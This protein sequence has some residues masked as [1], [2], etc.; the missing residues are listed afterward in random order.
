MKFN[1]PCAIVRDLLPSYAEGLTEEETTAAV[2]EHLNACTDCSRRYA[3]MTEGT[4]S[5]ATTSDKEVDY[6]KA[7]RKN[8]KKKMVLAVILAVVLV[9]GAVG[10]K[11]FLIGSPATGESVVFEVEQKEDALHLQFTCIDSASVLSRLEMQTEGDVVLITGRKTLVSPIHPTGGH[12]LSVSTEGIR[13]IRA[14]GRT[15]WQENLLVDFATNRLLDDAA[16]YVGDAPAVGQLISDLDLDVPST[17]ELQTAAAPYGVT[18]HFTQPIETN[19][20]FMVEGAAHLLLAL[21]GNLE[22]VSWDDP[23]GWTGSLTLEEANTAL[24][25]RVQRYN[26]LHGTDWT[27][28]DSVKHYGTDAYA[29]QQLRNLLGI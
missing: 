20:R 21:V 22:V 3:A 25:G 29:L 10:S 7:V 1:L 19:R 16:A 12:V 28:L 15:I 4:A 26:E 17:M 8:T 14:F 5:E 23:S 2:R 18:L 27:V 9:L 24:P 6:L 13:E 11:L